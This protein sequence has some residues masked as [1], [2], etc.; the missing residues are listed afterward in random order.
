MSVS[1]INAGGDFRVGDVMSRAWNIFTG[2][3]AFFLG[4]TLLIYLAII[5]VVGAFVAIFFLA[6]ASGNMGWLVTIGIFLA[7]VLFLSLNTIGEAVLLFGAFQVLRG[8]SIRVGEALQR[9]FAR[10]FP[11]I[12]LGI[13]WSVAIMFGMLLLI[14][15]GFILLCMW[16]VAV[17]ACVVEGLGPTASMS[18]SAALT[19]GYRWK[20]L[21]LLLLLGVINGVGSKLI[22]V[23]LGLA[24]DWL[25]SIGSLVWF[26]AWNAYWNCVLVMIYHDLR[27]AKEGVDTEQIAS[28]FD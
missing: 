13:L 16:A 28:V 4:I 7:I 12:G 5:V 15:P 23:I 25:S 1:S 9:A 24:G 19:K 22:E 2:N 18:R 6:G 10:F 27:V 21:G 8:Q 20:I 3:L 11:L 26:V 14:V 17:P